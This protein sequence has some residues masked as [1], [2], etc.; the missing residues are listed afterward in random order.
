MTKQ[1]EAIHATR[2][3]LGDKHFNRLVDALSTCPNKGD[4]ELMEE[5]LLYVIGAA[6]VRGYAA[7]AMLDRY[8]A[9]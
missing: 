8:W 7:R 6:G 5:A 2:E 1:D 3:Y 4:L 9:K